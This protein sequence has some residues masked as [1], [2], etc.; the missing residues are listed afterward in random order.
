MQKSTQTI[1]IAGAAVV[2]VYLLSRRGTTT[3]PYGYP[4]GYVPGSPAYN[5]AYP[6][7]YSAQ[8]GTSSTAQDIAAGGS[9]LSSIANI[10]G[11]FGVFG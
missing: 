10:L 5:P 11:N 6:G 2:G 7:G 8:P 4:S 1:L 3:N 9:A